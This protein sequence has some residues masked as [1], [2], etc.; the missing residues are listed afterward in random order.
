MATFPSVA[1]FNGQYL[2]K[3]DVCLSP[4]D[5]GF[6]FA[7]GVYEV[8]RSYRGKL[9]AADAHLRRLR[10]SLGAVR[11]E[12]ADCDQFPQI[13]AELVRR[14]GLADAEATVYLQVTRGVAPRHHPFPEPPPPPTVYATAKPIEAE[15]E[16]EQDGLRIIL[17]PD[18]RWG[19]CDIKSVALLPNVL[20]AQEAREAGADEAVFVREGLVTEGTRTNVAIV[21]QGALLT[22]PTDHRILPGITRAMV[23]EL[24]HEL[25]IA[26]H[27][28]PFTADELRNAE[29]VLIIGTTKEVSGAVMVDGQPVSDGQPGPVTRRLAAAYADLV[30]RL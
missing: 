30:A 14:S 15:S 1:Y 12:W 11:L 19:R 10:R 29:E 6:L 26:A 17:V 22:H 18:I 2:P 20:A 24:C 4:D 5:R 28:R 23:L 3:D 21:R 8:V 25:G 9:F 27:E 13:A 7:D 16:H